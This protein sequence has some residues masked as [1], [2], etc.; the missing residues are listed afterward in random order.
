MKY[1]VIAALIAIVVGAALYYVNHRGEP[2]KAEQ[3]GGWMQ[4]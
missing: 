2:P 3:G 1:L 4:R